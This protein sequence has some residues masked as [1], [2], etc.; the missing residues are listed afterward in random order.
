MVFNATFNNISDILVQETGVTEKKPTDMPQ[1]TDKLYIH[2]VHF[3][4]NRHLCHRYAITTR[5]V[6][7]SSQT[8]IKIPSIYSK[9]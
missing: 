5:M 2:A 9:K 6:S 7:V 3:A 4:V 1:V 8:L